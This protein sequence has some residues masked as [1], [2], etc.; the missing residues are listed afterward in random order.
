MELEFHK[1]LTLARQV[2]H[3][4]ALFA[5]VNFWLGSHFYVQASLNHDS[6]IY[7]SYVTGMTGML[8]HA[9]LLLVEIKSHEFLPGLT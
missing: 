3:T 5:L 4:P 7:T 2:S 9:Q 1:S 8:H 6:P